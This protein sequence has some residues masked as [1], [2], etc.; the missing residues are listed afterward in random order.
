MVAIAAAKAL[1][2]QYPRLGKEN[3]KIERFGAQ[4]LFQCMGFVHRIKTTGKVYIPIDGAQQEA[5]LKFLHQI[6][7]QVEKYQILLSLIINFDQT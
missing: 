7:N 6:V 2:K 3:L 5:E 4:S 1:L